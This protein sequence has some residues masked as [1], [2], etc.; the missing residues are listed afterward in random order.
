M[1]LSA[2]LMSPIGEVIVQASDLGLCYVGFHP[3]NKVVLGTNV[4]LELAISELNEYF[5]GTRTQFTVALDVKGTPFQLNVWHALTLIPYGQTQSYSWVAQHLSNPKAVRA[6][7]AANG[8]N[9]I[10][11]IVPCHRIIGANGSLTGYAGG[12]EAKRW[13]LAHEH[14][15]ANSL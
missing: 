2:T 13:L 11:F 10:S 14:R 6:V 12:L 9:P 3:V 5:Q 8:K 15:V 1:I 7:G 4:H